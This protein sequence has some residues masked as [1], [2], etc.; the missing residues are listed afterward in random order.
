[1]ARFGGVLWAMNMRVEM[2]SVMM[3]LAF[4]RRLGTRSMDMR[5]VQAAT[6]QCMYREGGGSH[7]GDRGMHCKIS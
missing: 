7:K 3:K 2:P 1:M 6:E 4:I 5:V